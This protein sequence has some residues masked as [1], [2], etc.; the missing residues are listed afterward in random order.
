MSSALYKNAH[1][2]ILVYDI[3]NEKSLE[4]LEKWKEEI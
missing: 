3:T 1:G 2:A 4:D